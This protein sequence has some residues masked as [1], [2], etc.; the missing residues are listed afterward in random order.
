MGAQHTKERPRRT[1]HP[2][3]DHELQINTSTS[4]IQNHNPPTNFKGSVA[5]TSQI[6]QPSDQ[7]LIA[8]FDFTPPNTLE[9]QSQVRVEKG[10]RLQ[11]FGYSADGD[12][13]DVECIRTNERGWIPTNYT[14]R[15]PF[16]P[17]DHSTTLNT[18]SASGSSLTFQH[19]SSHDVSCNGS[20]GSLARVGLESEKW[21]HGA[22]QRS[23]AEYLLNS[24]ITGSFLIRE[25]ESHPGQ[26]TISLRYEGQ[27][28][29]YRIHRDDSN[30]YYVIESNKFTSVSDLVHH[31]EKHS[32]GLA[33][34]LL[35]PAPKRDRTSSELRMDPS[36]DIREIDRTEIV[37]KH[38][39]G[40]GQ[41]GVVYEAVWKPYNVLVAVKTLK[42]NVTVR[43]EFLEEARLMKSLRHPNLVTL[44]GACTREPP[45]YIVT[46]FMCN[47]NLLDYLR[48]HPRTELTPSVLLHMATQVARGMAYL[49]QHNFIHRDLAARNCLVGTQHTIKVADFGLAR[50]IERDL[51]YRAHEGAKFPIKWTAPEGLV[52]NLF[53]TKSDVWAFGI[54][55][56]E[57][58]TYGKTPYPGVE[59]QDVY[60]LLERGTRML[61][62]EGCPEPVYEL[63][64]QCWQWLPEQRPPFS[65]ILNQLE[66]MPTNSTMEEEEE[67]IDFDI[68]STTSSSSLLLNNNEI[69][70]INS[71]ESNRS[72]KH[73][74]NI[75]YPRPPLPPRP[76]PPRRS[77]SC[78]YL[79]DEN[80][81]NQ[82][83]MIKEDCK[84]DL[85]SDI[86]VNAMNNNKN[87]VSHKSHRG[88]FTRSFKNPLSKQLHIGDLST[89]EFGTAE[90]DL[91]FTNSGSLGRKRTAPRPPRRTTPVKPLNFLTDFNL[92]E[93]N[94]CVCPNPYR[95]DFDHA[96]LPP[97]PPPVHLDS[98]HHQIHQTRSQQHPRPAP[99]SNNGSLSNNSNATP[100]SV[101]SVMSSS[102]IFPSSRQFS[103]VDPIP[104]DNSLTRSI[105]PDRLISPLAPPTPS[106]H[107]Q[108]SSKSPALSK[109]T[110]NSDLS[111]KTNPVVDDSHN[112]RSMNSNFLNESYSGNNVSS[113]PNVHPTN[114][115]SSVFQEELRDRLKQHSQQLKSSSQQKPK[116]IPNNSP[117]NVTNSVMCNQEKSDS[118]SSVS[119]SSPYFTIPR[120]RP[121]PRS[122]NPPLISSNN[123]SGSS[124][125]QMSTRGKVEPPHCS[126]E[127]IRSLASTQIKNDNASNSTVTTTSKLP[128]NIN[129][130]NNNSPKP[131]FKRSENEI[132]D[133]LSD[134]IQKRL[135]WTGP[136]DDNSA[137]NQKRSQRLYLPTI[138]ST[139]STALDETNGN[140]HC[141][142][143]TKYHLKKHLSNILK[144]L[145]RLIRMNDKKIPGNIA[146]SPS[147]AA[148][149]SSSSTSNL[150]QLIELADQMEACRLSCSAYIDQATCSARAKF[151]F[152]DRFSCLQTFSS[153]LRSKRLDSICNNNTSNL[154]KY[155]K[156]NTNLLKDAEN[157]IKEIINDLDK[158]TD[159]VNT[160][161]TLETTLN[162]SN[163]PEHKPNSNL[164]TSNQSNLTCTENLSITD[165][166]SATVFT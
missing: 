116:T 73:P 163:F 139:S 104:L 162:N 166:R 16:P 2:K 92:L 3:V 72:I 18:G 23:Y 80:D 119:N 97:P 1:Y 122:A 27:I 85:G 154:S 102:A 45:Y 141:V 30:M 164:A 24:G 28:W 94:N 110:V 146:S 98:S 157:A 74:P 40:S 42:E 14:G 15:I 70:V 127:L 95:D 106:K 13:S 64:L 10:D 8:L 140:N 59:L 129:S 32:D 145:E 143:P 43:D 77:T 148:I 109:S 158:L 41:Y 76:P 57:I 101:P 111:N 113:K 5:H 144:E 83:D 130:N 21:Y 121:P 4:W 152:R 137:S 99:Q 128:T 9:N 49:E 66:S 133:K 81:D 125:N 112:K 135:S 134:I 12:W 153:L 155:N 115:S 108:L 96:P 165:N 159:N 48:T 54:L 151:N 103:Y 65:D 38:K 33:C 91:P 55:L 56:W 79:I 156:N 131:H 6:N 62:P 29:H 34:T 39:L 68:T 161:L 89:D 124:N 123:T 37:M 35:Y 149:S 63:M 53:S 105:C 93:D 26:L 117:C 82:F 11:L 147:S 52:Y 88:I 71:S 132:S 61:C 60:V 100:F 107:V 67:Q 19:T 58:A 78:D 22:I 75:A 138:L 44:L 47:G 51:T 7:L 160:T 25:S 126:S 118:K 36:F 69:K 20:Q 50:C 46:E 120:L 17:N 87:N 136:T 84:S 90:K 150:E 86:P 142:P 31:H 114:I